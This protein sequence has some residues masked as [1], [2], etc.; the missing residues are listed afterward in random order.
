[1]TPE[2]FRR[3]REIF[4]E[5]SELPAEERDAYL[6][7]ACRDDHSLREEVEALLGE[8]SAGPLTEE[9]REA[10]VEL[11]SADAAEIASGTR[12]GAYELVREIGRGGMGRVYLGRRADEA[13]RKDVAVKVLS[14]GLDSEYFLKRFRDERQILA[15]LTHPNIAM[16]LDGGTTEDGLPYFVMEHVEGV[17][18]DQYCDER[19]LPSAERLRLLRTVCGAV[20]TAHARLIVHRDLKPSNMLVTSD[21]I[22][23]LLDFGLAKLLGQVSVGEAGGAGETTAAHIRML[24]PAYASPE[25]IRD[26]TISTASDVYSLGVLLYR[27]L[28]GRRP[29]RVDSGAYDDLAKAV[30]EQEP[31]RIEGLPADLE[32]IVKKAM[33][34]EPWA[35]Y[36]SAGELADDIERFLDG[37]PVRARPSTAWY[38]TRTF[39]KRHRAGAAAAAVAALSLAIALGGVL[40]RTRDERPPAGAPR[41]LAVL[42]FRS[43]SAE[44]DA[45]LELGM[46]DTLITRL[47]AMPGIALRPLSAVRRQASGGA[48][49]REVGR[50]LRVD[51]VVDGSF[52]SVGER[53]RVSVR[54]ID[55]RDGHA[56]WGQA[57]DGV[58]T[59]IFAVEDAI[60]RRVAEALIPRLGARERAQLVRRGTEDLSAYNAYLKGRYFWNRRTEADFRKAIVHFTQAIA[61]DPHYAL[62]HS[63]LADCYSLLSIWGAG[64]P[65]ETLEAARVAAQRAVSEPDAPGEAYASA[66]LVRWIYDWDWE[67]AEQA[68]RRAIV[69]APSYATARQWYAYDL[70]SRGRFDESIVQIRRA[71]ELDPL[72]V[73]IATDVGEIH[74]WAGRYEEAASHLRGALDMEPNFA[75]AHNMLGMVHLKAGRLADAIAE[76]EQAA[77]LD[78]SPR[79][80]G[81]LGYAYAVAGRRAEARAIQERLVAL[82]KSRYISAFPLA[83]VHTGL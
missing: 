73:S 50:A 36:S 74:L 30:C 17:P 76:L 38:R 75:I 72:S 60:T 82:S 51:A 15:S 48:D 28:S 59:D 4:D 61:A 44:R 55:V 25:Q 66:A 39:L 65:R 46:A 80:L 8:P 24:T 47:S 32:R 7:S 69:L 41:A 1:M 52:Q 42:P 14:A 43:L 64:P 70:A 62:A 18:I 58:R 54:L 57:F 35:R 9:V 21:G 63:G 56:I 11:A 79:M 78:D 83:L 37:R 22:P 5:V 71:L 67:G 77:R 2:L 27:L 16:L 81:V 12:V 31:A 29:Y 20:Q 45:V 34:K 26:E 13:F 10:V 53:L 40:G 68:F 33:R 3:T 49:A 19:K 6:A 23:K